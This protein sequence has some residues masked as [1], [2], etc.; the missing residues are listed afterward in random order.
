MKHFLRVLEVEYD[1]LPVSYL[2]SYLVEL[3]IYQR[4]IK[5]VETVARSEII[6]WGFVI[7]AERCER[8]WIGVGYVE[9]W[10]PI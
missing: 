8:E 4:Q 3:L 7:G 10:I 1:S 6:K 9:D 2:G 5:G